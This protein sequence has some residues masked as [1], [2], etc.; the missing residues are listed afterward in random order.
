MSC[1]AASSGPSTSQSSAPISHPRPAAG[2]P[3]PSKSM[4]ASAATWPLRLAT[5]VYLYSLTRDVPGVPAAELY[6]AVLSP[7]DDTNLLQKALDWLEGQLLVPARRRPRLPVLDPGQ[8]GQADPGGGRRDQHPKGAHA[9][10][11]DP[12]RAVQKTAS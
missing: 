2:S 8:P 10:D 3:T 6:G 12:V 4:S 7:G 5:A 9:S 11:Y 1:R